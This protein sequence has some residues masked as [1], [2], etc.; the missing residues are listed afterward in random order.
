MAQIYVDDIIFGGFPKALVDNFIDIMKSEFEMSMVGELS[1]FLGLQIK[2]RSDD[3][4]ISQEK[5]AKNIVKKFGLKVLRHEGPIVFRSKNHKLIPS[6]VL[7]SMC[8]K[9]L[10]MVVMLKTG[11]SHLRLVY[12]T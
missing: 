8:K 4:F 12:L 2:Q 7:I 1:Y 11:R 3:I 10:A 5:Y 6:K 9:R